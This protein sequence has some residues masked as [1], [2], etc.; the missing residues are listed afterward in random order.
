MAHFYGMDFAN[1]SLAKKAWQCGFQGTLLKRL[2]TG[3]K[4]PVSEN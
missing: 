3:P 4:R 2:A 1:K